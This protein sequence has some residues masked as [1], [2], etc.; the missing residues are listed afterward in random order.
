MNVLLVF[1]RDGNPMNGA[2]DVVSSE[3]VESVASVDGKGPI[4]GFDPLPFA[5]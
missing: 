4:L 1:G 5:T 3:Q 2:L